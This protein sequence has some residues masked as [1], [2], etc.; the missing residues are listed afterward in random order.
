[1]AILKSIILFC[2]I[3]N[4]QTDVRYQDLVSFVFIHLVSPKIKSKLNFIV[5]PLTTSLSFFFFGP[6]F[7]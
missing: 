6:P 7:I 2:L 3:I 1:M 4:F 5:E